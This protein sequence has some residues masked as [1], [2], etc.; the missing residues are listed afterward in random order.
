M[1]TPARPVTGVHVVVPARNEQILLPACL[2]AIDAAVA[3][4][5]RSRRGIV[6]SVL[7]VL[8]GCT[9]G[10]EALVR[11]HP[12]AQALTLETCSVGAARRRGLVEVAGRTARGDWATTWV[13]GTDADTVVPPHWLTR[14]VELAEAGMELVIG[15]VEPD[16]TDLD[17]AVLAR[18]WAGYSLRE[19]HG[20]VHGANLG[21]TLEAY[22][23]VGGYPELR[24]HEDVA[25][26][27][28]LRGAG[29]RWC[30]TGEVHVTTSGRAFGRTPGGFAGYLHGLA[31]TTVPIVTTTEVDL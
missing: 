2:D 13:A 10:T 5:S 6:A 14:Q 17:S 29:V 20:Q 1:T 18:W 7:V 22:L 12:T 11:R 16:A 15:T 24:E 30:A 28:L 9:D 8:D 19:G 23:R 25:L 21:F 26:V 27:R 31:A 4:L 3:H